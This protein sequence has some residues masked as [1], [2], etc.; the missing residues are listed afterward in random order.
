[1]KKLMRSLSAILVT[2]TCLLVFA[3]NTNASAA[4]ESSNEN[5]KDASAVLSTQEQY[6]IFLSSDYATPEKIIE[7]RE[8]MEEHENIINGASVQPRASSFYLG[9][10]FYQQANGWYCGPASVR[11]VCG[12]LNGT[13]YLPAQSE[14]A[15]EMG[16]TTAGTEQQSIINYLNNHT[17]KTYETYWRGGK[18]TSASVLFNLIVEDIN[19]YKP[20]VAHVATTTSNW[21]YYT[22]GHYL[23]IDGYVSDTSSGGTSIYIVDP[24]LAGHNI[25]NGRYTRTPSN[26]YN[27][28]DRIAT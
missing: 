21:L 24:W 13:S 17:N 18:Y 4:F 27:V 9:I 19:N 11:Q 7:Y 14:I 25:S 16:T 12:Y 5:V 3:F 20:V 26:V 15:Q 10:P 22:P 23:C 2:C 28:T 6:E 8:M 1:M